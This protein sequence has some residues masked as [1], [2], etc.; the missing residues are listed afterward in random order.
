[1]MAREKLFR[2]GLY[3]TAALAV[4]GL[5]NAGLAQEVQHAADGA[6]ASSAD[7]ADIVVTARKREERLQEVPE[8]ITVFNAD[9]IDRANIESVR[10]FV[11][12]TPN[13]LIRETFRTNETFL[14]M[15]GIASAQ[16]SLPPASIIVDGVQLGANDFL[17]Q[18]LID[19]ER[20]E[21]LKGP[22]GA[23]FG[24][25]AIAGA[26][27][28][29][30]KQPGNEFEGM[31]KGSY[32]NANTARVAAALGGPI[33]EDRLFFRLV[34]QYRTTDGLIKNQRGQRISF[35]N[36]GLVRGQLSYRADDLTISLR[37]SWAEGD[38]SCCIQDRAIR[39]PGNTDKTRLVYLDIDD[40]KNPG[41]SSNIIGRD[42][43]RF[44]DASLKAEYDFGGVTLTSISA[45]ADVRQAVFGDA[46][47]GSAGVTVGGIFYPEGVGQG[48]VY[49]TRF[50]NQEVRL[51]SQ[52][53]GPFDWI[54]GAYYGNRDGYQRVL[55]GPI[56]A[57]GSVLP[58]NANLQ[59]V[60][61]SKAWAVFGQADFELTDKLTLSGSL[62]YDK[63]RQDSQN[64]LVANSFATASFNKIQPKMQMSYK[65][66]P[67]FM[68]YSTFSTGFRTGGFQQNVKFKNESTKN[69]EV[70]F[71]S[72][73]ADG[74]V[75]LNGSF[76]HTDYSNQL[77][78]LVVFQPVGP[79]LSRTLNIPSAEIDGLE[80]EM[81]A[82]L[83]DRLTVNMGAG[84]IDSVI[85]KI[86]DDP[87]LTGESLAVGNKS[88]LV[89]P[90]TFNG[91]LTYKQPLDAVTDLVLYGS[92]QRVGGY[93]FDLN[94]DIRTGT[95][96]FVD[97]KISVDR[98]R[99]SVGIWGKNLTDSR[100]ATNM[101]ITGAD[102][103]IPNQPRSFGIEASFR[104]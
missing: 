12:L 37:G 46:D 8:S 81:S 30:T 54:V 86:A 7:A 41:A 45:W 1:M 65:W 10:D 56:R 15:R 64:E 69:Y 100:Q 58:V 66:S 103:R 89:S 79:A 50:W 92:Y 60:T 36:Q 102:L 97:G 71:K 94:N 62:R 101:S 98:E 78:S 75:T 83:S 73:F 44:R 16:G 74:M 85:K 72:T 17:T 19:I 55:V 4:P 67:D 49:K 99:W 90:F 63:D 82:R 104:F 35:S 96:D 24:Q 88:P 31:V 28:I 51:T 26:I 23:L 20:I 68:L 18:D 6:D 80:L 2:L 21:V 53:A 32:G 39:D 95:K 42:D 93:Y 14:T 52:N 77:L 61:N 40:V 57:D 47:F 22:Q 38:G 11:D 70:G 33:L 25:G 48:I 84:L 87:I 59:L 5:G 13:L 34:G 3:A 43:T 91:S 29:V 27:N 76:F 9:L